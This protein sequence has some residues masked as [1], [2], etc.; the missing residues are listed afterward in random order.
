[1]NCFLNTFF[2]GFIFQVSAKVSPEI[3]EAVIGESD[4]KTL[5]LLDCNNDYA[6]K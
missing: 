4:V 2:I 6:S 5:A 3:I 1:M